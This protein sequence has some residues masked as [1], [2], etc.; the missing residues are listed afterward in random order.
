MFAPHH[1]L[2]ILGWVK[3]WFE[4]GVHG[5]TIWGDERLGWSSLGIKGVYSKR[6]Q[7]QFGVKK[8][9]YDYSLGKPPRPP[10]FKKGKGGQFV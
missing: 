2:K 10:L 8:K 1:A 4:R 3:T 6:R 9:K 5:I 7:G